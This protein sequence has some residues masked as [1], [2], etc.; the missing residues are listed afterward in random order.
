MENFYKKIEY[1][2]L[3]I[4]A[5]KNEIEQMCKK[6]IDDQIYGVCVS[7]FYVN[8]ANEIIGKEDIKIIT[9]VG[10]PFGQNTIETKI[11]E[12]H[13]AIRNGANELEIVINLSRLKAGD[14]Q[15]CLDE[16]NSVKRICRKR[17]LKVIIDPNNLSIEELQLAIEVVL[18]SN[19]EYIRI[20]S[21]DLHKIQ[22]EKL[23][24]INEL[25]QGEKKIKISIE[26]FSEKDIQNLLSLGASRISVLN[27]K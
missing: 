23:K 4:E 26:K 27:I 22:K 18:E 7:P 10:Y 1:T 20:G 2:N 17:I 15:Y 11:Y 3:S 13:D 8:F 21:N 24:L 6:S 5:T 25:I 16:I 14:I 12:A 9:V 19:A